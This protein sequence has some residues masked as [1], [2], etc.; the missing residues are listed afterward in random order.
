[1]LLVKTLFLIVAW[2]LLLVLCWPLALAIL[3]VWPLLWL[4]SLPFRF[5]VVVV[6]ASFALLKAVLLLPARILGYRGGSIGRGS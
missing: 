5:L 1:V 6:E 2:C 4:L 3:V